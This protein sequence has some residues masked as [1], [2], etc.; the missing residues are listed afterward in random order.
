MKLFLVCMTLSKL[1]WVA[2]SSCS[3]LHI[4][5]EIAFLLSPVTSCL[6]LHCSG[7]RF[8]IY[9]FPY[10]SI[11]VLFS[12][13]L[14]VEARFWT[15]TFMQG[16]TLNLS[17]PYQ[18][19]N[20]NPFHFILYSFLLQSVYFLYFHF[21]Q[22]WSLILFPIP[23]DCLTVPFAL[24]S[25]LLSPASQAVV[26]SCVFYCRKCPRDR[27]L[28]T[29]WAGPWCTFQQPNKRVEKLCTA[30]TSLTTRTSSTWRWWPA[31]KP[32][33]RSCKCCTWVSDLGSIQGLVVLKMLMVRLRLMER[34]WQE[35]KLCCTQL[36]G[37]ELY[38]LQLPLGSAAGGMWGK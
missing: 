4:Q 28:K 6:S 14:R 20:L 36:D 31:P 18:F 19:Q 7:F 22:V 32:M 17:L 29:W 16:V 3:Q 21:P 12:S 34:F 1:W 33:L 11:D 27:P 23:L 9:L 5:T 2:L 15:W 13:A 24:Q 35:W 25:M 30:M 10:F 8:G 26:A 38:V 37:G